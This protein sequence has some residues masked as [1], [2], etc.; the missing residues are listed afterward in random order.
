MSETNIVVIY[1]QIPQQDRFGTLLPFPP[2][3]QTRD[4]DEEENETNERR[5]HVSLMKGD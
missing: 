2:K 3:E 1:D 5:E 4:D